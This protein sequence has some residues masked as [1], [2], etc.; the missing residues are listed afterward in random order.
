MPK[1]GLY[2]TQEDGSEIILSKTRGMLTPL[3]QGDMV[4][5][6]E[7]SQHVFEFAKNPSAFINAASPQTT[8]A[9]QRSNLLAQPNINNIGDIHIELPDVKDYDE[10]RAKLVKDKTFENAMCTMVNNSIMGKST[11]DKR[12][13]M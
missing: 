3:E 10:F 5:T 11:I 1:T 12:K 13:Y 6:A 2:Q 7:Q 4:L 9:I 8:S